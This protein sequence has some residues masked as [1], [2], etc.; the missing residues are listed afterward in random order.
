M[1]LCEKLIGACIAADCDNPVFEGAE[2]KAWIWN[3]TDVA[4]ITYDTQ[5][6]N[7]ITDISMRV[8]EEGQGTDPDV[9]AHGYTISQLGKTPFSGSNTSMVEGNY[10]NTFTETIQFLVPDNSPAASA[11]LDNMAGGKFFLVMENQY[12]GSDS[13][14]KFNAYGAKK[15]LTCTAMERQLYSDDS[16]G[17]W[18]VTLT[19][20]KQ[21]TS[22]VF[23]YKTDEATTRTYLDGLCPC[24]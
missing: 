15:A 14:G 13:K 18:L 10:G 17:G 8:I 12:D 22:G 19:A 5:D 6:A 1:A 21:P 23:V 2:P 4:S 20:E 16:M 7:I 3:K 24:E 11:L 9:L